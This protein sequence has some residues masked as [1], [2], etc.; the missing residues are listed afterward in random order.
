MESSESEIFELSQWSL[1]EILAQASASAKGIVL[2][3]EVD[4]RDRESQ[5][6]NVRITNRQ[7]MVLIQSAAGAEIDD[8]KT[9]V[10][11]DDDDKEEEE[12]VGEQEHPT[13][14]PP[15][16]GGAELGDDG[17]AAAAAAT[18]AAAAV[19][20]AAAAAAAAAIAAVSPSLRFC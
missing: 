5:N 9:G 10:K 16:T 3:S 15:H 2:D 4:E 14:T 6:K 8:K 13:T 18:A 1:K 12:E 11:I 17:A 20:A 19:A 7:L